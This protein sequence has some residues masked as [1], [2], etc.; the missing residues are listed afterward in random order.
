[1][2]CKPVSIALRSAV[3]ILP[4]LTLVIG[5]LLAGCAGSKP[6]LSNENLAPGAATVPDGLMPQ[7][8]AFN[9][10][11]DSVRVHFHLPENHL[12]FV[13]DDSTFSA[14]FEI[15]YGIYLDARSREVLDTGSVRFKVHSSE[16]GKEFAGSFDLKVPFEGERLLRMVLIDNN[17]KKSHVIRI[18]LRRH[19]LK[20][21]QQDFL[22][23]DK[24]GAVVMGNALPIRSCIDIQTQVFR[25]DSIWVRWY[26][27]K[28]PLPALPF[29]VIPDPVFGLVGDSTYR[30]PLSGLNQFCLNRQGI[31]YIQEDTLSPG[32]CAIVVCEEDFPLVTGLDQ[33]VEGTRYLTT[34]S[35]YRE[36]NR[37]GDRKATF[38]GFWLDV[39][40]SAER[41]RR[42]IKAYYTHMQKA[43]QRFTSY[44]A[45]WRTDRG[46]VYM[47][48]GEPQTIVNDGE[49]EQW[50]YPAWPGM[51]DRYFI[52]RKLNNPFTDN[53]Y[54]LIRQPQLEWT[55]YQAVE[56]WRN[57]R[58]PQDD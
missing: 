21:V 17:R 27:K 38:D 3:R 20:Q 16:P 48:F 54:A 44:T 15:A 30:I 33:L 56:Q 53:D 22:L 5:L 51:P 34:K 43:N 35:E 52:F 13:R 37:Q 46:M 28:F 14:A 57:G 55:W 10:N 8:I 6:N 18:N 23:K 50:N 39:G 47:V 45:G 11:S 24:Q 36:L 49:T 40:G 32:G 7:A 42:L 31:C 26:L 12:L 58:I 29:R 1:M 4:A 19:S 2:C 9:L 25:S 41:A